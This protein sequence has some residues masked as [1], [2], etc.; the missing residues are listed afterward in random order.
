MARWDEY[1]ANGHG[2]N[3]L[4]Q[5]RGQANYAVSILEVASS[6]MSPDEIIGRESVWKDKLGS[7]AHGLNAN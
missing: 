3:Q 4:L 5:R 1:A 6:E 7:R 2:G